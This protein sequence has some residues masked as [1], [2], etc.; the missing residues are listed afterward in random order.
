MIKYKDIQKYIE[1]ENGNLLPCGCGKSATMGIEPEFDDV[2]II[3]CLDINC[4]TAAY[5]LDIYP[6]YQCVRMW[7]DEG[8]FWEGTK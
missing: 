6:I 8:R 2:L 1:A 3:R 7:N 5:N 4:R